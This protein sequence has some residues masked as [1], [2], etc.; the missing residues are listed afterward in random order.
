MFAPH[1]WLNVTVDSDTATLVF[2]ASKTTDPAHRLMWYPVSDSTTLLP[3]EE[4]GE[5]R[6]AAVRAAAF[7]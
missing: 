6:L 4:P 1:V 3:S 7:E 2:F 5:S